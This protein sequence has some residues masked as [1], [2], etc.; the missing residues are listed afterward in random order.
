MVFFPILQQGILARGTK[1]PL[2]THL[3]KK[4]SLHQCYLPNRNKRSFFFFPPHK[5]KD[6]AFWLDEMAKKWFLQ[7]LKV[8]WIRTS[9]KNLAEGI[10]MAPEGAWKVSARDWKRAK[11][12]ENR[13][14]LQLVEELP[15]SSSHNSSYWAAAAR[16]SVLPNPTVPDWNCSQ[17]VTISYS[18]YLE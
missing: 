6:A 2:N 3:L 16:S 18:S 15:K 1:F 8:S 14:G 5:L 7:T 17:Q 10:E 4:K 12:P 9:Y 13:H 11:S